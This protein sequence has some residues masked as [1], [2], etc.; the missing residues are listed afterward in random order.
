MVISPMAVRLLPQTSA[1]LDGTVL[2]AG[3]QRC[4]L[5]TATAVKV[6]TADPQL[7]W[8]GRRGEFRAT[9]LQAWQEQAGEPVSVVTTFGGWSLFRPEHLRM[10]ARFLGGR[11]W[12]PGITEERARYAVIYLT[13]LAGRIDRD[14]ESRSW[15]F[16]AGPMA[17]RRH[18]P[19][20]YT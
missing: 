19:G 5:A 17:D 3:A 6:S 12:P 7:D 4:D 20:Q 13:D 2:Q 1:T 9:F 15:N 11:T 18:A 10:L 16:R 8:T 14:N